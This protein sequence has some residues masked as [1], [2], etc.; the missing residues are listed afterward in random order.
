MR[1][2]HRSNPARDP[3][4]TLAD[5]A[6]RPGSAV[7]CRA[8]STAAATVR[9]AFLVV[10]DRTGLAQVVVRDEDPRGRRAARGDD[11]RGGRTAERQ[12]AG[13]RRGRGDR[14][15]L[16]RAD[17]AGGR[18]R[19]SS[20]GGRP[21]TP[22]CRRCSTTRRSPGGIRPSAAQ[23]GAGR[24]QPARLPRAPS[25]PRASPRSRPQ[26]R[27][28]GDRARRERLPRR[29]LRPAG[30]PRAE[31]AVLQADAGRRLR[32]GLR[33]RARC[34][35]PSRTTPCGTSPS[36]SRSTSSSGSSTTTAT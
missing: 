24:G 8:G 22:A 36:T 18:R 3:C 30:V 10:R 28:V 23:V 6:S 35:A 32:A 20:C 29:L 19:R 26:A 15:G 27:R 7:R 34:S 33:G 21:S 17:R 13:A 1:T 4:A 16:P 5:L 25:T 11:G 31:P 9:L 12:P 2:H 14:A